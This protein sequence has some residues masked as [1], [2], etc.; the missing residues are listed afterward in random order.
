[1]TDGTGVQAAVPA[2]T[3]SCN[4][5]F[6]DDIL[7]VYE[8]FDWSSRLIET[9]DRV[10]KWTRAGLAQRGSTKDF[11]GDSRNNDVTIVSET[12][13][14]DLSQFEFWLC[15][16]F[17]SCAKLYK[18][19]NRHLVVERDTDLWLLRYSIGQH[20]T[21]HVDVI[22]GGTMIGA[23][24][25]SAIAFLNDDYDGGH[26]VFP[27]QGL[28]LRPK[29]GTVILFPSGFTHPHEVRDVTAGVRYTVVTWYV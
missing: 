17:H 24:Q 27:R 14:K 15:Q 4:Y 13:H 8:A 23:R 28:T 3:N 11:Y 20:F 2:Q 22:T 1:V 7:T 21:E 18:D 6:K 9:A 5:V 12:T 10:N 29:P 19:L 25:L 26:L 16:T